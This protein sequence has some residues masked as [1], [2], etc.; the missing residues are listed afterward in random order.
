MGAIRLVSFGVVLATGALAQPAAAALADHGPTSSQASVRISVSVAPKVGI[1]SL[2][3]TQKIGL[4]CLTG[5]KLGATATII[6]VG[7]GTASSG[8]P[9]PIESGPRCD[10]LANLADLPQFAAGETAAGAG[11]L[12]VAPR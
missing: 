1:T 11:L 3:R 10:R 8:S 2:D 5:A 12:L 7:A 9:I 4:L 6:R